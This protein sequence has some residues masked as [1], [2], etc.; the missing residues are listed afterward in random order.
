MEEV[1]GF[2]GSH[3]TSPSGEY[4]G[5]YKQSDMHTPFFFFFHGQPVEKELEIKEWPLITI[6]V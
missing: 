6:G 2:A 1:Q 3:W 4:L 5:Q